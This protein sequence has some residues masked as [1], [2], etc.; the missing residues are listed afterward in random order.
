MEGREA[1]TDESVSW[2]ISVDVQ[3]AVADMA[4]GC[5]D[6]RIRLE[7]RHGSDGVA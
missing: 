7:E 4:S 2:K 3:G 6:S 1:S 5:L